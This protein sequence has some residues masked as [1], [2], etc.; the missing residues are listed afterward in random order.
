MNLK[1]KDLLF[2]EDQKEE[3]KNK[4]SPEEL[5]KM[6][7]DLE[8]YGDKS[9]NI[10]IGVDEIPILPI[11]NDPKMIKGIQ[12]GIKSPSSLTA[13]KQ[14]LK[15]DFV[16]TETDFNPSSAKGQKA[17]A[18]EE[19][20][21]NSDLN[22]NLSQ[23]KS[24]K[25]NVKDFLKGLFPEYVRFL[26]TFERLNGKIE[27]FK[28]EPFNLLEDEDFKYIDE[29]SKR[30]LGIFD[31]QSIL[32]ASTGSSRVTIPRIGPVQINPFNFSGEQIEGFSAT[33]LTYYE[34]Y[35]AVPVLFKTI[36][37]EPIGGAN[38]KKVKGGEEGEQN[39]F[40][41]LFLIPLI[42]KAYGDTEL[43]RLKALFGN[44]EKIEPDMNESYVYKK[45]LSQIFETFQIS[46]P[47]SGLLDNLKNLLG[48]KSDAETESQT[49][50][51]E[52]EA[53]DESS[54][55][56]G[57]E[58]DAESG[59][60]PKLSENPILKRVGHIL[61]CTNKQNEINFEDESLKQVKI[62]KDPAIDSDDRIDGIYGEANEDKLH[63]KIKD[64]EHTKIARF[65]LSLHPTKA[66]FVLK[67]FGDNQIISIAKEMLEHDLSNFDEI[68][69]EE[70]L[71][72]L[73]SARTFIDPFEAEELINL[74]RNKVQSANS[75]AKNRL[76][77]G[78][79][80]N[81][82]LNRIINDIE[83]TINDYLY[84]EKIK[85]S[86]DELLKDTLYL[87]DIFIADPSEDFE[88]DFT[89]S[90]D[91]INRFISNSG[92]INTKELISLI[93][94]SD[95][96]F[97]A[98]ALLFKLHKIL[99]RKSYA[100]YKDDF[101]PLKNA[102]DD[103]IMKFMT[104]LAESKG[105]GWFKRLFKSGNISALEKKMRDWNK[106][107]PKTY[108]DFFIT[109]WLLQKE[110][111]EIIKNLFENINKNKNLLLEQNDEDEEIDQ[112]IADLMSMSDAY[113]I[114]DKTFIT[115]LLYFASLTNL[116]EW[117]ENNVSASFANE[118]TT[119]K[120]TSKVKVEIDDYKK[121]IQYVKK[122][123]KLFKSLNDAEGDLKKEIEKGKNTFLDK[124][125]SEDIKTDLENI[126]DLRAN[127]L[128]KR[129]I[130]TKNLKVALEDLS[131]VDNVDNALKIVKRYIK[132]HKSTKT[133]YK[134]LVS[135]FNKNITTGEDSDI[136]TMISNALKTT[137]N[138]S[139]KSVF[140]KRKD[141]L[142]GNDLNVEFKKE[143]FKNASVEKDFYEKVLD[144]YIEKFEGDEVGKNYKD[145]FGEEE[146][147]N[148]MLFKYFFYPNDELKKYLKESAIKKELMLLEKSYLKTFKD[149]KLLFEQDESDNS[150]SN[151]ETVTEETFFFKIIS[152]VLDGKD[153][154][155]FK[156]LPR[157]WGESISKVEKSGEDQEKTIESIELDASLRSFVK[158]Y[159]KAWKGK[160]NELRA[161]E[162]EDAAKQ[163]DV[164]DS[165]GGMMAGFGTGAVASLGGGIALA[166][167]AATGPF[168]AL[169]YLAAGYV[170]MP[171]VGAIG[172]AIG[173]GISSK[174]GKGGEE[175]RVHLEN[176]K[177]SLSR[178]EE[179]EF[180]KL[181]NII[182]QIKNIVDEPEEKQDQAEN[183]EAGLFENLIY[184]KGLSF[185]FEADQGDE[186]K[187]EQEE[188]EEKSGPRKITIKEVE[189]ILLAE[190]FMFYGDPEYDNDNVISKFM[191]SLSAILKKKYGI[192]I[193][194]AK[195]IDYVQSV[196]DDATESIPKAEPGESLISN[197]MREKI[198]LEMVKSNDPQTRNA[199]LV[200][201]GFSKG[202]DT[203]MKGLTHALLSDNKQTSALKDLV[204]SFKLAKETE[205]KDLQ[206]QIK[207][208]INAV[209]E[210]IKEDKPELAEG[211]AENTVEVAKNVIQSVKEVSK[212][213]G[214]IEI[215]K[216][217]FDAIQDA[218]LRTLN[219]N[220]NKN[221]LIN[222][223]KIKDN[224][225]SLRCY[226]RTDDNNVL[227]QLVSREKIES[228]TFNGAES[229]NLANKFDITEENVIVKQ[230]D[231]TILDNLK[232][233][234]SP[235]GKGGKKATESVLN[236]DKN[237][238]LLY[239][240]VNETIKSLF[241]SNSLEL[242]FNESEDADYDDNN[243]NNQYVEPGLTFAV[244]G[245]PSFHEK[246]AGEFGN[247]DI[248]SQSQAA[249]SN[250]GVN[251]GFYK[252][253]L[254]DLLFEGGGVNI[255]GK[256]KRDKKINLRDEW[257]KI[258]DI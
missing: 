223:Y 7:K 27:N 76:V 119:S 122:N 130:F 175:E 133:D 204:Q 23:L 227:Q 72:K 258:W 19:T 215:G 10:L 78:K 217:E 3:I 45:G 71:E 253:K 52:S 25:S 222:L 188:G 244:L 107:K 125:T 178:E 109:S 104:S 8:E 202:G 93:E 87:F 46:N 88:Y 161:S 140:D 34:K 218:L 121:F 248:S 137:Y 211:L 18:G 35:G 24:F 120:A 212:S 157:G 9:K 238:M 117:T 54:E 29:V 153:E 98:R 200:F 142:I 49:T 48:S 38:N 208:L 77:N 135:V 53:N 198:I 136:E 85:D 241:K 74:L 213:S 108:S 180:E 40:S 124:V 65:L 11:S 17:K 163:K 150:S 28:D 126:I 171:L 192:E 131:N 189:E 169:A 256:K 36:S 97:I 83:K 44:I 70:A 66:G 177:A 216:N 37:G 146:Y 95:P 187:E 32:K 152:H 236:D 80:I 194:D 5:E 155:T 166:T 90:N 183:L 145:T 199:A 219:D 123:D 224:N 229:I 205:D 138:K 147:R 110:N 159:Y 1:L 206:S 101:S 73:V 91:E 173:G 179:A 156:P 144:P 154:K 99:R 250:E 207:G 114:K 243:T 172:G 60:E 127:K 33:D 86:D 67:K 246:L 50:G 15:S 158:S 226:Y 4:F 16:P 13:V 57:E 105:E 143:L 111:K 249:T 228:F 115:D 30:P 62:E 186:T 181:K 68:E 237:N 141:A 203:A 31:R 82:P 257:L 41:F 116:E 162:L 106:S 75:L 151:S 247:T 255:E 160:E 220:E 51:E 254:S 149:A 210:S 252:R 221:D 55:T 164:S 190:Q 240:V 21:L 225:V 251:E 61:H 231:M 196:V 56:A 132:A 12:A 20:D 234:F 118:K 14:K 89:A 168:G 81:G 102:C 63:E 26:E 233:S 64:L 184:R 58:S 170:G 134:D 245:S 2:E 103:Y 176:M 139:S 22:L 201:L 84:N 197:E 42:G 214:K 209:V 193:E 94:S 185:L 235:Y 6:I 174:F 182:E 79:L 232:T 43:G 148:L 39:K 239:N 112:A 195:Q 113:R 230:N 47:F 129:S 59:D 128:L 92:K 69:T 242:E 96:N 165:V 167:M 191:S 100:D